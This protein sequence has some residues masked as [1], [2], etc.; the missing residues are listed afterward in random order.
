[1]LSCVCGVDDLAGVHIQLIQQCVQQLRSTSGTGG[2]A[3]ALAAAA[4]AA[5]ATALAHIAAAWSQHAVQLCS[6][7][8]C[9]VRLQAALPSGGS[10]AQLDTGLAVLGSRSLSGGQ[11]HDCL[12]AL[13]AL[14]APS[15]R[16][17]LA[18]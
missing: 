9:Y 4:D 12:Q 3:A 8:E 6:T 16:I 10:L 15:R 1:V 5:A 14:A 13:A 11:W 17:C 2:A 7:V 18:C